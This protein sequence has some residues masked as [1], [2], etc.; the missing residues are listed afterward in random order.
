[1]I[2]FYL[3][4][5]AQVALKI[6][7][8]FGQEVRTLLDRRFEAGKHQVVWDGQND[9]GEKVASGVYFLRM[10]ATKENKSKAFVQVRKM[11]LV[12]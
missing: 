7:N 11:A 8:T 4:A 1:M 5:T 10:V 6:Y 12:Q 2:R 3:P 9:S